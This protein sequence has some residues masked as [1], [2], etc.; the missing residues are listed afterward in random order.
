MA[1]TCFLLTQPLSGG[2]R[3]TTEARSADNVQDGGIEEGF[4]F[5]RDMSALTPGPGTWA[6]AAGHHGVKC[7][8]EPAREHPPA[9][10]SSGSQEDMQDPTKSAGTIQGDSEAQPTEAGRWPPMQLT[11]PHV[12]FLRKASPT[13]G[14]CPMGTPKY[15]CGCIMD[16]V[17]EDIYFNQGPCLWWVGD[18]VANTPHTQG[19]TV[20]R[21]APLGWGQSGAPPFCQAAAPLIAQG[22]KPGTPQGS[23]LLNTIYPSP[24]SRHPSHIFHPREHPDPQLWVLRNTEVGDSN[25]F[26]YR[27]PHMAKSSKPHPQKE[28]AWT[29][30]FSC[31][32][33]LCGLNINRSKM[34]F[35][36]KQ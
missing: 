29:S 21:T 28:V 33:T 4:A 8:Q 22:P 30:L 36:V 12:C 16:T 34:T 32:E 9:T 27:R 15:R 26:S 24:E 18:R 6:R 23:N 10:P 14:H 25:A 31:P 5:L 17:N 2:T 1:K 11:I 3:E 13:L 35:Q 20:D 7:K 19:Q